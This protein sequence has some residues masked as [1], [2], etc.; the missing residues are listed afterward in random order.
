MT[1]KHYVQVKYVL[2]QDW[3]KKKIT[4]PHLPMQQ[5]ASPNLA[6]TKKARRDVYVRIWI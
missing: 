2:L 6:G 5:K 3:K 4:T 1:P